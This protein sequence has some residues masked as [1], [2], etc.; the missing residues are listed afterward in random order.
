MRDANARVRVLVGLRA[1]GLLAP[2]A[3]PPLRVA[4][5]VRTFDAD[6]IVG[7]TAR[8]D[9][10]MSVINQAGATVYEDSAADSE[11]ETKFFQTGV[12]A[13]IGDLRRLCEI[14]LNRTVDRLLDKPAFRAIVS[15]G[16]V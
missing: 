10:T 15:R 6:M 16:V 14:V 9:L 5:V 13:D 11:S 1:R 2:S 12:L 8:I 4:L 3:Q 7:R